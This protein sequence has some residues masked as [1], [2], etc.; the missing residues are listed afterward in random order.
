MHRLT[1]ARR[2][3]K[4]ASDEADSALKD[5]KAELKQAHATVELAKA[6]EQHLQALAKLD[7]EKQ[8]LTRLREFTEKAEAERTKLAEIQIDTA[9]LETLRQA[10]SEL[11]VAIGKRDTATS[12]VEIA[13]E[14]DLE[15]S[16]NDEQLELATGAVEK[17]NVAAELRVGIPGVANIRVTPS[18]SAADL[19]AD[20]VEYEEALTALL[21]KYAVKNLAD[22]VATECQA[23]RCC[24]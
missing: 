14:Q 18:Q 15:I 6:D 24:T 17:R 2:P 10:E 5:L 9:G 13:A 7:E 3:L 12:T 4:T 21:D 1:S 20:V 19:E 16:F 8:R 22:A 11:Q 23:Y